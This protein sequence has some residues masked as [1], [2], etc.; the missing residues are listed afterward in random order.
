MRKGLKIVELTKE[1][2]TA[3][4]VAE[5]LGLSYNQVLNLANT[6]ALPAVRIGD[7]P[8]RFSRQALMDYMYFGSL[9]GQG[10]IMKH[11]GVE[12]EKM[13]EWIMKFRNYKDR[14][15]TDL[16]AA[17]KEALKE[18]RGVY[19]DETRAPDDK[20][21]NQLADALQRVEVFTPTTGLETTRKRRRT[22]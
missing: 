19:V 18:L 16:V 10:Q 13:M 21:I 14:S 2:L 5:L 7:R 6:G 3:D 9:C 22:A 20:V 15:E 12:H 1:V 4:E 17:A 11:I 8:I